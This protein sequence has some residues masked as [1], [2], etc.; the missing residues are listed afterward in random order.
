MD[1]WSRIKIDEAVGS[2]KLRKLQKIVFYVKHPIT[3]KQV[4]WITLVLGTWCSHQKTRY[5]ESHMTPLYE[6]SIN[7]TQSMNAKLAEDD[8]DNIK[9]ESKLE[10]SRVMESKHLIC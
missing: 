8:L 10:D 5:T 2:A 3:C 9:V 4:V 1:V 7:F 6:A